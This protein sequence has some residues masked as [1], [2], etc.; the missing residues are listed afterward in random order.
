[1]VGTAGT[2][3]T[4][5]EARPQEDVHDTTGKGVRPMRGKK[6]AKAL[7]KKAKTEKGKKRTAAMKRCDWCGEWYSEDNAKAKEHHEGGHCS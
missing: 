5:S 7:N 3:R 1:M 4:P 6:L 2:G